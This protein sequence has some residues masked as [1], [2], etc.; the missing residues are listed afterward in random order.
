MGYTTPSERGRSSRYCSDAAKSIGAPVLH[1]N[2]DD[3]EAVVLAARFA[4]N[5]R[6]TYKRDVFVDVLCYRRYHST[7]KSYS[8]NLILKFKTLLKDRK[9]QIL[10]TLPYSRL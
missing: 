10:K 5:Y 2:G 8:R 7:I 4:W 6:K 1:V 3:P 9:I